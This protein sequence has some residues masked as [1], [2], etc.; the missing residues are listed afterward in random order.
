MDWIPRSEG[1]G[2]PDQEE[3][4]RACMPLGSTID[5]APSRSGRKCTVYSILRAHGCG[6]VS[7]EEIR[8]GEPPSVISFFSLVDAVNMFQVR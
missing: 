7:S 3:R 4:A 2:K 8:S 1:T 6:E 5:F